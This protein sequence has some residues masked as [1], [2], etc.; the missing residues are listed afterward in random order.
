MNPYTYLIGWREQNKFYY[1]ARY[2]NG[3]DPSD[4]LTTYFTSSSKVK[5]M[6]DLFGFPDII[7]IRKKFS[8]VDKTRIWEHKVLRRLGVVKSNKW[9]NQTDNKSIEPQCGELNHMFGKVGEL[10]HRFGK[11]MTEESKKLIGQKS[12]LKKGNMPAGFSDK[13][14]QIVT[15]RKHTELTKKKIKDKLSGRVLSEEHK[16]NISLNHADCSG[17][18]N[19]FFGKT[20]TLEN[21]KRMSDQRI[22]TAMINKNGVIKRI[23]KDLLDE[24]LQQGWVRGK[25]K[26]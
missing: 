8:T 20:H 7:E 5:E 12:K 26:K 2:A 11:S 24:Y 23:H 1:G 9:L 13:M 15:G 19:A 3:C 6:I 17:K 21:K 4:L 18:N 22:G 14:R 25:G 16:K 10:S